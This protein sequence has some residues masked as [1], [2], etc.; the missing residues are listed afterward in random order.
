LQPEVFSDSLRCLRWQARRGVD[1][2]VGGRLF[3]LRLGAVSPE[4]RDIGEFVELATT[5]LR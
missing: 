3:D 4:R 2:E 5:W 1:L